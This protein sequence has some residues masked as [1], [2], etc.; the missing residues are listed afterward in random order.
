MFE[1]HGLF[2]ALLSLALGCGSAT[3]EPPAD[4]E[5]PTPPGLCADFP[6]RGEAVATFDA[7]IA[8]ARGDAMESV[9]PK[10]AYERRLYSTNFFEIADIQAHNEVA[11]VA[12]TKE[13][14]AQVKGMSNYAGIE[15][16]MAVDWATE[17]IIVAL[18]WPRQH[19]Y[20]Y[21]QAGGKLTIWAGHMNPCVE[22]SE[23]LLR[24]GYTEEPTFLRVPKSVT[25]V[26]IVTSTYEYRF[27]DVAPSGECTKG[28]NPV[29]GGAVGPTVHREDG[30][31]RM[32]F[33]GFSA[34]TGAMFD[35][36]SDDGVS[37]SPNGWD[38]DHTLAWDGHSVYSGHYGP[39]IVRPGDGSYWIYYYDE[40]FE[41]QDRKLIARATSQDGI[42]FADEVE[43]LL[44]GSEGAW[45]AGWVGS[46]SVLAHDGGYLMWYGGAD[47]WRIVTG[48]GLATSDDGLIWTRHAANPVVS[49]R[50][51][52]HFDDLGVSAPH[53]IHDGQRFIL[54]YT[55][56]TG[57]GDWAR[58]QAASIGIAFSDDGVAWTRQPSPVVMGGVGW[59]YGGAFQA[60]GLLEGDGYT[61]W[62][63]SLNDFSEPSL[64]RATCVLPA[65]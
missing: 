6:L 1:N 23:D 52:G 32:W 14:L 59:E 41:Y 56:S 48:I 39:S 50:P 54:W 11:I 36:W 19:E 35:T 31:Y 60:A 47:A 2:V 20:R 37:W 57:G 21:A 7:V 29:L 24:L 10:L 22:V 8:L 26:E 45:D 15:D 46:P 55:G 42:Q 27:V 5:P 63:T 49:P 51:P 28:Q 65:Q 17:V 40:D 44:P 4:D 33:G 43:V 62:Y 34:A 18:L 58:P 64:G 38:P 16:E 3:T 61:V 30:K 12:P 9:T 25:S 13:A 53:V